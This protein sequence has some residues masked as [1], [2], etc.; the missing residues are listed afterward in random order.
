MNS[1]KKL[2]RYCLKIESIN[3]KTHLICLE[4]LIMQPVEKGITLNMHVTYVGPDGKVILT[5]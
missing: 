4:L 2:K 5:N 3:A 1:W